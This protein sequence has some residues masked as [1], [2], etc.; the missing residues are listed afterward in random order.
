[1][2]SAAATQF[3][4]TPYLL[5]LAPTPA[6][7]GEHYQIQTVSK[8]YPKPEVLIT[9]Q[10]KQLSTRSQWLYLCF[11]ASFHWC[12][13]RPSPTLLSPKNSKMADEYRIDWAGFNVS[14][15]TV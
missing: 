13:C 5:P 8:N 10:R 1:V 15:N 9:L 6:D 11:G 2:I 12:I 14:T 4:G 3:L 7:Y